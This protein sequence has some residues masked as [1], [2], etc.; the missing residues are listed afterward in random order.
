M[1]DT[2][3]YY[4]FILEALSRFPA[5]GVNFTPMRILPAQKRHKPVRALLA[6]VARE[7][8]GQG[9]L[10]VPAPTVLEFGVFQGHS[11]RILAELFPAGRIVGFD[12][13][14][15]LPDD[16]RSDWKLDFRVAGLPQVPAHVELVAGRFEDTLP[17]F[18]ASRREALAALRLLHIDCDIFSSAHCVFNAL[19]AHIVPGRVIVFDELLNYDE[20]AENELLA[21]YLFLTRRNLGFEWFVTVGTPYPFDQACAGR[22]PPGAFAGYREH[23]HYQNAAI[24]I[25]A[26]REDAHDRLARFLPQA[27]ALTQQRP[28]R[29]RV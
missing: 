16:G 7:M 21:L 25:T 18:V 11:T 28:L 17:G 3:R 9:L 26:P 13:F 15:G 24:V 12:T 19:D 10:D 14:Q 20:F 8:A 22:Q 1:F 27:R 29:Q 6:R 23:G 2:V 5:E 4:A